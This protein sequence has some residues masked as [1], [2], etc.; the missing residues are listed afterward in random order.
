[1]TLKYAKQRRSNSPSLV[2]NCPIIAQ[3]LILHRIITTVGSGIEMREF[4]NIDMKQYFIAGCL[5]DGM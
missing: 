2:G 4:I 1:M 5:V 3:K